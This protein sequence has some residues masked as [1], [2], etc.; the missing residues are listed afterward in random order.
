MRLAEFLREE[1]SVGDLSGLVDACEFWIELWEPNKQIKK[2]L[3]HPLSQQFRTS[4]ASDIYRSVFVSQKK[5][6]TTNLVTLKPRVGILPYSENVNWG[7]TAR[8]DFDYYGDILKFKKKFMPADL[9][10]NF[11]ALVAELQ[12]L[13]SAISAPNESELWMKA[14]PYY[15]NFDRTELVDIDEG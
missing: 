14:T 15:I 7:A 2:I 5:F 4:S 6:N 1:T 3:A 12:K 10:L 9:I 8:E 11:S 13:G